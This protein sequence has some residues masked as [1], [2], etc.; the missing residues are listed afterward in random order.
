MTKAI[1]ALSVPSSIARPLLQIPL[2]LYRLG[3][4]WLLDAFNI[5][6]VTTREPGNDHPMY[7]PLEYRRH[8][9]KLYALAGE[10]KILRWL[11]QLPAET[12]VTICRGSHVL[13]AR[14]SV[15]AHPS[16]TTVV[17]HLFRRSSPLFIL[18]ALLGR[19]GSAPAHLRSQPESAPS[20]LILRFD[21]RPSAPALPAPT[22]DL[23]WLPFV[24]AGLMLLT[25]ILSFISWVRRSGGR[26]S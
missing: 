1:P 15:V 20:L 18:D 5:M 21:A 17:L 25:A 12:D 6:I 16:E 4:G 3:F 9:R 14:A 13:S 8:G 10:G 19:L 26:A 23:R 11:Q 7:T 24:A 22:D 2:L